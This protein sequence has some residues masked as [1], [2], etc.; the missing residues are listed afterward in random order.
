MNHEH[1]RVLANEDQVEG[2]I[3][4]EAGPLL[5]SGFSLADVAFGAQLSN[6]KLAGFDIDASRWPKIR[7]YSDWI[8]ARPSFQTVMEKATCASRWS[9]PLHLNATGTKKST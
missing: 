3:P 9:W 7:T 1:S 4:D 8:L 6:L 5:D 2:L